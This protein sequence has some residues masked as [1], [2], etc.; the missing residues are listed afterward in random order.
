MPRGVRHHTRVAV[1][2]MDAV[3]EVLASLIAEL[4]EDTTLLEAVE[5]YEG[6]R[7]SYEESMEC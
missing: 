7:D 5:H 2:E 4:G 1:A 6:M 3:I